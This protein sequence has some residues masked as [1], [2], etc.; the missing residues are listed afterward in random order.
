MISFFF[1]FCKW[2]Y[3]FTRLDFFFSFFFRLKEMPCTCQVYC[4][5]VITEPWIKYLN[6]LVN[7]LFRTILV[8]SQK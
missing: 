3:F 7:V 6:A 1:F 8:S 4:M 5:K 2:A